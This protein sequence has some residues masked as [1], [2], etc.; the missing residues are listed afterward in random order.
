MR[1][2][3]CACVCVCVCASVPNKWVTTLKTTK[4]IKTGKLPFAVSGEHSHI[5][6]IKRG[7]ENFSESGVSDDRAAVKGREAVTTSTGRQ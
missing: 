6:L 2:R 7:F 5:Y 1:V 3:V 4:I